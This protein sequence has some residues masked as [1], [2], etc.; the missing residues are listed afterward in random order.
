[1]NHE[2]DD[3][4]GDEAADSGKE[5]SLEYELVRCWWLVRLVF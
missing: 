4:G 2:W 1:M 5:A 3:L